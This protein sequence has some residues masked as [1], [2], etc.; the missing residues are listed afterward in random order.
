MTKYQPDKEY[1]PFTFE[2][3]QAYRDK[4]IRLA[5]RPDPLEYYRITAISVNGVKLGGLSWVTFKDLLANY[6]FA[7]FELSVP[8]GERIPIH[9]LPQAQG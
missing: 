2:S 4:W 6:V 9:E 7:D 3:I 1:K 5:N 8:V